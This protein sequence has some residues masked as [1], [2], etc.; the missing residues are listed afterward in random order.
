[1]HR[2]VIIAH[3]MQP[4]DHVLATITARHPR[5]IADAQVHLAAGEMKV[6][7]DLAAG[8]PAADHQ[9]CPWRELCRITIGRGVD[10]YDIGRETFGAARYDRNLIAAGCD[11]HLVG[12]VDTAGRLQREAVVRIAPKALD[13]DTFAQWRC[14]GG[15]EAVD[16]IDDLVANH[17][18]VG[19]V[20]RVGKAWKLTLPI[21]RHQAKRVPAFGPPGMAGTLLLEHDVINPGAFEV[22]AD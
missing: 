21:R 13:H 18:T 12:D 1:M 3:E 5:R 9:H 20:A 2:K 10:L 15:D 6:L 22:P 16:V 19:I 11:H 17:E 8:L 7:G 4:F 14:E